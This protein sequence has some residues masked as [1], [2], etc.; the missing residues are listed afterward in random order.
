ERRL[1]AR[2]TSDAMAD[3]PVISDGEMREVALD[4]ARVLGLASEER[5]Y[6]LGWSADGLEVRSGDARRTIALAPSVAT[7]ARS[8]GE[9]RG[10]AAL[11]GAGDRATARVR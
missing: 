9:L 11:R 1:H 4:V 8:G 6:F 10:A 2:F 5:A 7:F 3:R